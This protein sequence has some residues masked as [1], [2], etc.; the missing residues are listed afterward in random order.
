MSLDISTKYDTEGSLATATKI[1]IAETFKIGISSKDVVA[2]YNDWSTSFEAIIEQG[3][4]TAPVIALKEVLGH[5]SPESRAATTVLDVG[6]GTGWLGARL[7]EE[8]FRHIHALEPSEGM[9]SKLRKK[10][11]YTREFPVPLGTG[12]CSIPSD[13]YDV[14]ISSGSFDEG[15]IPVNGLDELV[16][17]TK[18]G[19]L[20]V[21]VMLLKK[22]NPTEPFT[23]KLE[24]HMEELERKGAWIKLQRRVFPN[25]VFEKEGVLFTFHVV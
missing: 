1:K 15:H 9:R 18:K 13:T 4:Y 3:I 8:G 5:V 6:A 19:G 12:K 17:V 2:S 16:R 22:L 10:G 7:H 21:I 24:P 23:G 14:V 25:F 20:V 11:V